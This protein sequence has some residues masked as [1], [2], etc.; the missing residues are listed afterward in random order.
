ME[1]RKNSGFRKFISEFE[2]YFGAIIFIVMTILLFIQV[3]T[4]YVLGHAFTWTEEISTILFVWMIY[5][6]V[7]AAVLR[8]KHLKIDALVEAMPFKVKKI[9]LIISNIIFLIFCLYI[10]FPLFTM[11]DNFATRNAASSILQIPKA[12]SYGMLPVCF[13]LTAI[14]IVQEIIVLIHEQEKELGVSKPTI[15][16]AALEREALELKK[17]KEGGSK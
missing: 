3:V 6:G 9:M 1:E 11:V 14:R 12:I 7:A 4:R 2:I 8:R 13:I 15:D 10:Q 17:K 5:L 16:T